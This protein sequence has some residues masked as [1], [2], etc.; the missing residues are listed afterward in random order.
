MLSKEEYKLW[1]EGGLDALL[2]H[3]EKAGK[4]LVR[5]QQMNN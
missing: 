3:F 5:L 4:D 2:E 1:S